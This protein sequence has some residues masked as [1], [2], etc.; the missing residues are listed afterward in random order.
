MGAA[1]LYSTGTPYNAVDLRDLDFE[2]SADVM[3]F[4]H[5]NYAPTKVTRA[6]HTNWTFTTVTFGPTVV[7]PTALTATPSGSPSVPGYTATTYNY[8]VTAI[9]DDKNQ[10][11]RASVVASC[12]NDLTLNGHLNTITWAAAADADR[13]VVY[14][15]VNGIFG[16]IGGT[17][18]LTFTDRNIAADLSDTPPRAQ[19]PFEGA[20]NYP[21]TVTFFEQRLMWAR[22]RAKP[23][24]VFGSQSGDFEN[25]DTSRP[26]KA[27]DALS[28]ALVAGRVNAVNQ[29][30][31]MK[32]LLALTSDAVFVINGGSNDVAL[33]PSQIVPRRQTGRGSSR[34]GP[35]VIDNIVFY[36]PSQGSS[37]R[38]LGYTFELDGYQ[39]NNVAIFS[40]HFFEGF[41]I[42]AW[43]HQQ[44]P[45]ACIWAARSDGKLLCFTWEQEQQVW[46]WTL[47]DMGGDVL[48]VCTITENGMDRL[49]LA[50]RRPFAGINN[51]Y[52]ERMALPIIQGGDMKQACHLDCS[53]SQLFDPPSA[54]VSKLWHLEG[55]TVTAY[56]D[57]NVTSGLVVVNGAVTLPTA[58]SMVTVGLPFS[59]Q[60]QTLPLALQ[61][62]QGS[63]QAKRQMIGRA[64]I[65]VTDTRG[66]KVGPTGGEMFE[67]KQRRD[68]PIGS[69]IDF[70]T[71]DF[72][73]NTSAKWSEG[74][75]VTVEQNY[76]LPATISA[77]FLEPVVTS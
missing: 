9:D 46:G 71:G 16:Y 28:F 14:K 3:Y 35:L 70:L 37:V 11:S 74:A 48:D 76:P 75:T 7:A 13:Y 26:A 27:D 53:V 24:A 52:I 20:D 58:A 49:Y 22:T 36:R 64:V 47:C 41:D 21:S 30:A 18:G 12:V 6:G 73:V 66:I 60:V 63:N 44:E 32:N 72:D 29:L 50:V 45:Y 19:N 1:R 25:Q 68:E 43:A 17:D 2:Q 38:T 15:G 23:N 55:Q 4:A 51:V 77:I 33:T 67:V 10:E 59:G 42:V 57:G 34:L 39:S 65:R 69:P 40:P 62:Q 61:G 8:V 54:T 5:I 56:Y 31:S